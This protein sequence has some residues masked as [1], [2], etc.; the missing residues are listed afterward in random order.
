[1]SPRGH[2]IGVMLLV[3]LCGT[4]SGHDPPCL[5]DAGTYPETEPIDVVK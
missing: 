2:R 3:S 4:R 1:V 5:L